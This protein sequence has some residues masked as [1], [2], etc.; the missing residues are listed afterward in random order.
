MITQTIEL[1]KQKTSPMKTQYRLGIIGTGARAEVFAKQLYE[2]QPRA[3]LAAVCDID[4]E[5]MTKFVNHCGI[6]NTPQ[7]TDINQ[8]LQHSG[9][10]AVIITTP[11]FTH[12]DVACAALEAGKP[13]YLEK[14]LAHTLADC[15][16]IV[17]AQRRTGLLFYI[18][19]NLRAVAMFA[20]LKEVVDSG[21]LGHIVHISGLE[22]LSKEHGAAYMRRFHRKH[23]QSGGLLNH[24]SSHD[25]D[26][27]LWMIGHQHKVVSVSS[28]GGTNVFTADKQPATHCSQC[29]PAVY[30]QCP[31]KAKAG[32]GFP[33]CKPPQYKTVQT[34][35]YGTDL[36]VY[37]K[38]KDIVD[39]Q[40]VIMEWEHGVR[41][42]YS[43]QMFQAIGRREMM[44]L[45]EKG[46]AELRDGT[47][48]VT[49]SSHGDTVNYKFAER[50]GGHGGGDSYMI[51]RFA[52]ALDTG[53]AGDSGLDAGY[54]ATQ[55]ALKADE[56]RLVLCPT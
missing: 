45:G 48:K 49:L 37:T 26:L 5:R 29:P 55:V 35:I 44:V 47:V 12:A 19:F 39:N 34:D 14:P 20:K 46:V 4:G 42:T 38:D 23:S 21:V 56:S 8:F 33:N 50:K 15:D 32:F 1:T 13:V 27:M 36:C 25:L 30:N 11:D 18:G 24:K 43:L 6:E 10:D 2:G 28:F 7:Y 9:L 52:E 40:V 41:G 3:T 16:R 51:G 54:A 31:Y 22:I 17:Q 53:V